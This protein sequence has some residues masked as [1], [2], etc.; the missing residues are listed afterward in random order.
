[1]DFYTDIV[2]YG[3]AVALVSDKGETYTYTRLV[4]DGATLTATLPTRS[5]VFLVCENRP[6]SVVAYIGFLRKGIVPVLVNP[7]IDRDQLTYLLTAYKPMYICCA[8]GWYA[9]GAEVTTYGGYHV[10][11]YT[12]GVH[13]PLNP[14]LAVLITTSGSTGSPK[15]VM[16]SYTNISA[17]AN[18]I[19]DYL[20]I[21]AQDRAITT[22][23]MSYTYGLSIIQSHL[24]MGARII[25][26]ERTLMEKEFWSLFRQEGATTFGGVP[27]I[28]EMLKRLRFGRMDLPT[29]KY[30][31]QA[32]G[33]LSKELALEFSHICQEKGFKLVVMYGQT[34]ATARMAYLPWEFAFEK[35]GSIGIAIPGGELVLIDEKG[36][37]ITVPDVVG[38]MVYR[39]AN[40]TLGYA[41]EA[42]DL[43]NEDQRG[44]V[45]ET[46]DMAKRDAD[47]F[48]YIVGRKKRFLKLFGNRVNLDEVESILNSSGFSCVCGG[49]DDLL[50][51]YL[52][53][54]DADKEKLAVELV[55]AKTGLH[56]SAFTACSIDEIPRNEAG[57]VLYGKLEELYG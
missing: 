22:M 4:A 21:T 15:L 53:Q 3:E 11:R 47:G 18:S 37:E 45:L 26:T 49:R 34:E 25:L 10:L 24:L 35:A 48:F 12:A 9:E 44:G 57:K 38:E 16:Q 29:L 50:K 20:Q 2:K 5:L 19:A 54:G 56:R 39:G 32:G 8:Q 17:N 46:G 33:K 1:M 6:E 14:E 42:S 31:T 55:S 36:T 40:V 7:K 51:I 52:V 30:I 28:Y 41:H 43:A 23:P 13:S 27:Y